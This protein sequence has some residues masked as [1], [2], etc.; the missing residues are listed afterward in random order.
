MRKEEVYLSKLTI[1]SLI[2]IMKFLELKNDIFLTS[3]YKINPSIEKNQRIIKLCKKFE[4]TNYLTGS[5]A[6]NYLKPVMFKDNNISLEI[7]EYP[8]QI[9]YMENNKYLFLNNL[10]IIDLLFHKGKESKKY[11]QEIN[12]KSI[13]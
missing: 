10:S 11:L 8:K 13:I 5:N 3:D 1:A 2:E 7:V 4:I 12:Y 6:L 9:N